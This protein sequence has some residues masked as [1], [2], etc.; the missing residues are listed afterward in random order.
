M[1]LVKIGEIIRFLRLN[2]VNLSQED[3]AKKIGLERTY[4]SKIES[5]KKNLTLETLNVICEGFNMSIPEFFDIY[6]N[7]PVLGE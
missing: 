1:D 6:K 5:G 7:W 4:I 2:K 3:F